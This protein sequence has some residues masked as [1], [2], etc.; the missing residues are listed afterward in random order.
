MQKMSQA[1]KGRP[2]RPQRTRFGRFG[3]PFQGWFR[4]TAMIPRALPW[5]FVVRPVGAVFT[6]STFAAHEK[7]KPKRSRGIHPADAPHK[8]QSGGCQPA[9]SWS[10]AVRP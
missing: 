4:G 6:Q 7:R 1:L 2:I 5:A 8:T 10:S 3:S 9:E